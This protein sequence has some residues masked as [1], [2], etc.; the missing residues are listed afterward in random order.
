[1]AGDIDELWIAE[2]PSTARVLANMFGISD[3]GN[4]CISGRG[5]TITWCRG[6]LLGNLSPEEYNGGKRLESADLPM[7]P[8]NWGKTPNA[9]DFS[10][11][12]VR[13]IAGLLKRTK[14]VV[15]AGDPDREGQLIVDEVLAFCGWRGPVKR[16]WL[17][18]MD[19]AS[20]KAAIKG[21]YDNAKM[22]SLSMAAETRS[23]ADWLI[24]F[25]G[26]MAISRK[27]RSAGH[28]GKWSVGRVQT[29]VL[30]M[31]VTREEEIRNFVPK[32]FFHVR[33]HIE[34]GIKA[35]WQIPDTCMHLD[36]E[37]RLLK[38]E[39]ADELAARISGKPAVVTKYEAKKGQRHAPLPYML[40][41]LQGAA[42][43]RFGMTAADTLKA[44]QALYDAGMTTYPRTDCAYLPME[45]HA[46]AGDILRK[47]NAN[48]A[49]LETS[50][51]HSAWNTEKVTAHHAI[52]PTGAA[53]PTPGTDE[54]KIFGLISDA[55]VR[56][57]MPPEAFETRE[58]T[59]VI[60][61][62]TFVA[63]SRTVLQPGWT[64]LSKGED[65]DGDLADDE[66]AGALPV[67]KVGDR[68]QTERGEVL[69]KRTKAPSYY[70]DGTL[71]L[72]MSR[73]HTLVSDPKLK[74]R[75]RETSGI[76]TEATRAAMVEGLLKRGYIRR[77]RKF[78]RS[79]DPGE[80]LLGLVR[81]TAPAL[82]DVG[83]TAVW[84]DALADIE[85]GRMK[86]EDFLGYQRK[87]VTSVVEKI[88]NADT[89]VI[90]MAHSGPNCTACG[91]PTFPRTSKARTPYFACSNEECG[92]AFGNENGALGRRFGETASG[93]AAGQAGPAS[94]GDGPACPACKKPTG[95][96]LTRTDKKYFRCVASRD[97]GAWWANDDGS[98]GK[99]WGA[100]APK[101]GSRAAGASSGKRRAGGR[102]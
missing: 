74:A 47:L 70:T 83:V 32:D 75:L 86:A 81:K 42:S 36:D 50:R 15:H 101:S 59:F 9:D 92:A 89:N 23:R 48:A 10:P 53:L 8:K 49:E 55:Y 82:A 19:D 99:E 60:E 52:I 102:R 84:E 65:D 22:A 78:I 56:L 79:A 24:G 88:L 46:A 96:F 64:S 40:S 41:T 45:Q 20:V 38:K 73:V 63:R 44:A 16:L 28:A 11:G 61:G 21:V 27:A 66:M 29:P 58:A 6:H 1:M 34:Q 98:L 87:Q 97:H 91:S 18:A 100:M 67:L 31:V 54:A 33:A 12:Q 77:D 37:G 39:I 62:E 26:S 5:I 76:G 25:N 80:M 95:L 35:L 7:F 14:S 30:S 93:D 17:A 4:N 13:N 68:L 69:S 72:A 94:L 51:R 90:P 57:F 43:R 85:A 3:K 71:I 2:K